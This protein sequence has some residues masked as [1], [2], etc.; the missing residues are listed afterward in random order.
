MIKKLLFSCLFFISMA[1]F[2][3]LSPSGVTRIQ[4]STT[5]FTDNL[6]EGWILI[7]LETDRAYKIINAIDG[8]DTTFAQLVGGVD[9]EDFQ[10]DSGIGG[11]GTANK[12]A[13]FSGINT[14]EDGGIT[15]NSNSNALTIDVNENLIPSTTR[16]GTAEGSYNFNLG[17]G[18]YTAKTGELYTST[19]GSNNG[20]S[21]TGTTGY[22]NIVGS[23]NAIN[24]I[25]KF[26]Y[27]NIVG[28]NNIRGIGSD[29]AYN[30]IAGD[31]IA[32]SSTD[33]IFYNIIAGDNNLFNA[34]SEISSGISVGSHNGYTAT[35]SAISYMMIG[36][37]IATEASGVNHL[38]AAGERVFGTSTHSLDSAI[39]IG[40]KAGYGTSYSAPAI[41]GAYGQPTADNQVVI[42][43]SFYTSG[44]LLDEHV[45]VSSN[46]TVNG[47][48]PIT[49]TGSSVF[50]GLYSGSV[51]DYTD[52]YNSGFGTYSLY[53]N[54]TT[55]YN[56][57][58]GGRALTNLTTGGGNTAIGYSAGK[59]YGE[60][61]GNMT[62]ATNSVFVGY[63]AYPSANAQSNEIVIG[64]NTIGNGSNTVTL[65]DDNIT[66]I[67]LN[68]NGSANLHA[69]TII[70]GSATT[71]DLSFKT[72]TG[73]GTTGADMH[74]LV[75]N[76]GAT[77]AMTILNSGNVG[78]GTTSPDGSLHVYNG[79]LILGKESISS[80]YIESDEGMYFNIDRN[81]NEGSRDFIFGTDRSGSSGGTDLMVI[82]DTGNVGIGTTIPQTRLHS[83]GN[84][85]VG[86]STSADNDYNIYFATD[87]SFNTKY[88]KWDDGASEF[89]LSDDLNLGSNN[90]DG[91]VATMDS[92]HANWFGGSDTNTKIGESGRKLT[93]DM[94]SVVMSIEQPIANNSK[95][96]VTSNTIFDAIA[97]VSGTV[98]SVGFGDGTGFTISGSPITSSGSFTFAQ[99]FSEFTDITESTGIKFV[100]TDPAEKE[101]PIENIDLSDFNNDE[102][103]I[104]ANQ[105]I[106]LSGDISG[107]GTTSIATTIGNDKILESMLKS[108]NSPTDEYF[109]TYESTTGDFEWQSSGASENWTLDN[110]TLSAGAYILS[111]NETAPDA[112]KGG[113]TL[114]QGATDGKI[115][116]LKSSDVAHG[117]T[118]IAETDTYLQIKKSVANDGGADIEGFSE[119]NPALRLFGYSTTPSTVSG[120]SATGNI[121]I[122]AYKKDGSGLLYLEDNEN[123][124]VIGNG[125]SATAIFKG[126]GSIITTGGSIT[127]PNIINYETV[128]LDA[129]A[130][131]NLGSAQTLIAAQGAGKLIMVNQILIEIDVATQL[132]CGTQDL[133]VSY[134]DFGNTH[135]DLNN[136]YVEGASDIG[137]EMTKLT[138]SF[139]GGANDALK[140]KL[141]G[142][143]NPSSGSATM[144]FHIIYKVID[145]SI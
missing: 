34:T 56:S 128:S 90:I 140:V 29:V 106:T 69:S 130:V 118:S 63:N 46:L 133:W 58:I 112:D 104:S 27:N 9:Y 26:F 52:N 105:T 143:T 84:I 79:Q 129:T 123:V 72:T 124:L 85:T 14:I 38:I 66:D 7:L 120:T 109:L 144:T 60:S 1:G 78:I 2:G 135:F 77:E 68:E 113:L 126:D 21:F 117:I 80:A 98:T 95:A 39:G 11:S 10:Q 138:T 107:S 33:D 65:G 51:D 115:L 74:F 92:V 16:F 20:S 30:I 91:N 111:I 40:Y 139:T 99:D 57:A 100:V 81:A 25:D 121:E 45:T 127:A 110:D 122:N 132:E 17:D 136:A 75:G 43:S 145:I 87:G 37:S 28:Y 141:S 125:G 134:N 32:F 62:S 36:D 5:I 22:N 13:R 41:F 3:Q 71:S 101:I 18:N 76:N 48:I 82:R 88:F 15:D 42:G 86:D 4:D 137:R 108:V 24:S 73:V 47:R 54:V 70:G 49:G 53:N 67:Y 116:T 131:G 12:V 44:I 64:A 102:G 94:D 97:A 103:F 59:E 93:I 55:Q 89:Q 119:L 96:L 83:V 142:D 31:S 35:G 50:V 114:N 19:V 61:V 8:S 6:S 23:G